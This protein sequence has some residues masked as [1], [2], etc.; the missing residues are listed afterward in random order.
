MLSILRTSKSIKYSAIL[1]DGY[2]N[3]S[4]D[5]LEYCDKELLI[6]RGEEYYLDNLKPSYNILKVANSRLG[7]IQS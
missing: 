6:K 2:I 5:I 4:L 3:F 7:S 1:K